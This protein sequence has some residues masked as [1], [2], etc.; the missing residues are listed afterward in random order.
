MKK[1]LSIRNLMIGSIAAVLPVSILMV[2]L[3]ARCAN[4]DH[5]PTMVDTVIW[6]GYLSYIGLSGIFLLCLLAVAIEK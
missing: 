1:R 6:V 4:P 2:P 3:L 5:I